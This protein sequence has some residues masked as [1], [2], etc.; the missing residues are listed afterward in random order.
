MVF[1]E[2]VKPKHINLLPKF[3]VL[4]TVLLAFSNTTAS[5]VDKVLVPQRKS[6]VVHKWLVVVSDLFNRVQLQE[7]QDDTDDL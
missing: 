4:N 6:F 3:P 7:N 1:T 2:C 5:G